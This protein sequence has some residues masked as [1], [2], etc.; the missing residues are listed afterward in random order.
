MALS[1]QAKSSFGRDG[2]VSEGHIKLLYSQT[3]YLVFLLSFRISLDLILILFQ[4]EL[5][6]RDEREPKQERKQQKQATHTHT[7]HSAQIPLISDS[8]K[9]KS[10]RIYIIIIYSYWIVTVA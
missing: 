6:I 4:Q 10:F 1:W 7:A 8:L 3:S 2:R 5:Q 9:H